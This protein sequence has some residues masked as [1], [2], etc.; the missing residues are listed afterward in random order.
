[1]SIKIYFHT[2]IQSRVGGHDTLELNAHT[3]AEAIT[4][5]DEMYPGFRGLIMPQGNRI[6]G[7]SI[8]IF[9]NGAYYEVGDRDLD[10]ELPENTAVHIDVR[11]SM[12]G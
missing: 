3:I 9:R 8:F 2:T 1:M 5:V 4:K 7:F 11:Q 12:G 6:S 10:K